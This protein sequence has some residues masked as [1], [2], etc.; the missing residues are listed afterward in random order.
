ML[1]L[2][3]LHVILWSRQGDVKYGTLIGLLLTIFQGLSEDVSRN[4]FFDE[5]LLARIE[6]MGI[7]L[8]SYM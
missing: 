4:K 5:D 6:S 1:L 3:T 2:L 7:D 8:N